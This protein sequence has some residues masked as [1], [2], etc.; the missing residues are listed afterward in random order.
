M[1]RRWNSSITHI[2]DILYLSDVHIILSTL[3]I[4]VTVEDENV[5][6][7]FEFHVS[8]LQETDSVDVRDARLVRRFDG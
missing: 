4:K 1:D 3:S 5:I 2:F 6:F 7:T 8:I